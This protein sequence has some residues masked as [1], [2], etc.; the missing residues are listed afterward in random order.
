[1]FS[2]VI[3]LFGLGLTL[4]GGISSTIIAFAIPRTKTGKGYA[5]MDRCFTVASWT[6]YFL[7][8]VSIP[9]LAIQASVN[10]LSG[11]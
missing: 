8:F 1:M 10:L 9:L 7:V 11:A 6:G 2:V 3:L 5:V 4:F